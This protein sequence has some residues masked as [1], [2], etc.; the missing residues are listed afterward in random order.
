M[1]SLKIRYQ[2]KQCRIECTGALFPAFLLELEETLKSSFFK[3]KGYSEIYFSFPFQ[4]SNQECLQLYALCENYHVYVM[5][6][7]P[8]HKMKQIQYLRNT[9]HNG[10][11]YYLY[12]E[13][14]YVGNIEKDVRIITNH[15]LYI[16]G[17]VRGIIDVMHKTCCLYASSLQN[18]RIRIF[19]SEFHNLTKYAPCKVYYENEKIKVV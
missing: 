3:V 18:C 7:Q 15:D 9:F 11:E 8:Y 1:A 12:E 16:I 4:L 14:I 5:E 17:E 6:I 10:E 19:D 2:N 13:C